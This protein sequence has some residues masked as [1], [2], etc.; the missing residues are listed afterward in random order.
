MAHI[1]KG[2]VAVDRPD[3][4]PKSETNQSFS[5]T[6]TIFNCSLAQEDARFCGCRLG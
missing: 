1:K 5:A 3:L 4:G 6:V 2:F